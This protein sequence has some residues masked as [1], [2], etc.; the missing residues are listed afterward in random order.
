MLPKLEKKYNKLNES[1]DKLLE[2]TD[3]LSQDKLNQS[4]EGKW[5][6]S[7][8]FYHLKESEQGTLAYLTKK[9]QAPVDE[10]EGG[11]LRS[12]IRAFFLSKALRSRKNKFRVPSV[13]KEIPDN[14]SYNDTRS[15]YLETRKK[16]GMLLDRFD[17]KMMGKAYFKHP[18]AG[19]ITIM[20]TLEFLKD[21]FDR[22]ADQIVERSSVK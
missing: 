18:R 17:K 16:F 15:E 13:F 21:H 19:K 6:A 12:K 1:L 5:N 9:I 22:H 20:Q 10:V 7:Q 4:P 8:I 3:S 2:Y 11:G 14:P